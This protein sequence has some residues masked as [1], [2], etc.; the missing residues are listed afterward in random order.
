AGDLGKAEIRA[1][2]KYERQ[3]QRQ[4]QRERKLH[5]AAPAATRGMALDDARCARNAL[6]RRPT[7]ARATGGRPSLLIHPRA[8]RAWIDAGFGAAA[9]VEY[10]EARPP[11]APDETV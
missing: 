8:M 2:G 4:P 3:A 10:A 5:D 6:K 11:N 1:E 7:S 9:A